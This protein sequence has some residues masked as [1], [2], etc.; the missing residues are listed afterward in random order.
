MKSILIIILTDIMIIITIIT[1]TLNYFFKLLSTITPLRK[2]DRGST[3]EREAQ[4]CTDI[5]LGLG[6]ERGQ[7]SSREQSDSSRDATV[8]AKLAPCAL[9]LAPS[10]LKRV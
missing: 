3:E 4:G 5:K 6:H 2:G 9:R 10:H 8:I 7:E 1:S